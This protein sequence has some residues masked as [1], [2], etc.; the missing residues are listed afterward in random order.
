MDRPLPLSPW[1]ATI[2]AILL[3]TISV[4]TAPLAL[5][6]K[7]FYLMAFLLSPFAAITVQKNTR[8][9]EMSSVPYTSETRA[10]RIRSD[11]EVD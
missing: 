9:K 3:L 8:D 2:L 5:S 4:W 7:G 6:E 1:L 11:V 10:S